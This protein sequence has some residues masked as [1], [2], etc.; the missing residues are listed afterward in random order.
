MTRR[1]IWCEGLAGFEPAFSCLKWGM[2]LGYP[3]STWENGPDGVPHH[4][5]TPMKGLNDGVFTSQRKA[6]KKYKVP[7]ST[8]RENKIHILYLPLHVSHILQP[9]DLAPF[10]VVKSKYRAQICALSA[11]ND[12]APVK[13]ENFIRLYN[14]AREEGLSE[15]VIRSGWRATGLVPFNPEKVLRSSQVCR[16]P[17]TPPNLGLAQTTSDTEIPTPKKALDI[18]QSQ[19]KI[20]RSENISHHLTS[21]LKKSGQALERS[22]TR[23]AE[24][25]MEVEQ[26]KSE[27]KEF[28]SSRPR[29]K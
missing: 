6:A 18:Y 15:R 22:D 13:K 2:C 23:V 25:E 4:H 12:T 27:N 9:L 8:L 3:D 10:S 28:K 5:P 1:E 17:S 21:L 29:K 26:L 19:Q 14:L 24:L 20:R 16:R 11:L 7:E